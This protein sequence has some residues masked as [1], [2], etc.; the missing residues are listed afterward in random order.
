ML[1]YVR[2]QPP[3]F[4]ASAL[5]IQHEGRCYHPCIQ[6]T[7]VGQDRPIGQAETFR[8]HQ[9]NLYHVV[10]F[11]KS[12]GAFSYEGQVIEAEPGTVVCI[13]PGQNHDFVTYREH[14]VYSEV[15]FSLETSTAQILDV[16]FVEILQRYA[17]LSLQLDP[18]QTLSL[19]TAHQLESLI[20]DITDHARSGADIANYCCQRSL[21]RL[22]DSLIWS[23][24]MVSQTGAPIDERLVKVKQFIDH[25]YTEVITADSLASLANM[26]KGYL[27]RAFKKAYAQPPATYQQQ[28]RLE[29]AKTLLRA[30]ALR[31]HEVALRCGYENIQFFH[32][33]FKRATG[34]TPGQ[35]RK[36][37]TRSTS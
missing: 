22:F 3:T 23:C 9:H 19:E 8:E 14:A 27:F 30:T 18:C 37:S 35:Y 12:H 20:L 21:A 31:C 2:N 17:G 13:S 34:L 33:L 11:M 1:R 24:A 36:Q 7:A 29:A 15:T 28:L 26:S 5:L 16:P 4:H 32:R 25:H 6:H 10:V